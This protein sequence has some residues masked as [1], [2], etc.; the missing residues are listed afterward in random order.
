M[1]KGVREASFAQPSILTHYAI[2]TTLQ[3]LGV[4][5]E[6][7][8]RL[9]VAQLLEVELGAEL[10]RLIGGQHVLG[11]RAQ[12]DDRVLVGLVRYVRSRLIREQVAD[13]RLG[14]FA[15]VVRGG[16]QFG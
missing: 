11:Q 13:E 9:Q 14:G 2:R 5:Q 12:A 15:L 16:C 7:Q 1:S 6:R 10:H 8:R 3:Q 4:A